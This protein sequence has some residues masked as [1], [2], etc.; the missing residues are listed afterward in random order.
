[1]PDHDQREQANRTT[2]SPAGPAVRSA[3]TAKPP[4]WDA[5]QNEPGERIQKNATQGGE[6]LGAQK[7]T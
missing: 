2:E 5:V 3:M 1:M 6:N 4:G 7:P